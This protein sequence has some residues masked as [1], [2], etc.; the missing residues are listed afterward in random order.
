MEVEPWT[1]THQAVE[2][3]DYEELAALLDAGADPNEVCFGMT[4]LAH[5]IELEGDSTLQSG[6]RLHAALTAIVLAY[7]ADPELVSR[8]DQTPM[9][10]AEEYDHE[11]AKRLLRNFLK[12][13]RVQPTGQ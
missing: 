6:Y 11:P 4:L 5:A 13:G 8:N 1:P 2:T 3:N 12:R 9:E 10:I 7:G